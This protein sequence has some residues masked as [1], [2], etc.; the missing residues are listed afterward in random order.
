MNKPKNKEKKTIEFKLMIKPSERKWIEEKAEE[1]GLTMSN[2]VR[3]FNLN[4]KKIEG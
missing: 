1:L 4:T 3:M 2:V